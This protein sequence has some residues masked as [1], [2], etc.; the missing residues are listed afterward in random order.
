MLFEKQYKKFKERE[1]KNK[2]E[3]KNLKE[4][5]KHVWGF[6]NITIHKTQEIIKRGSKVEINQENQTIDLS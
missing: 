1:I 4:R 3:F 5:E 6:Q 2:K